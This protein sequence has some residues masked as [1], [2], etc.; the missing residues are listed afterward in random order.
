MYLFS[1]QLKIRKFPADLVFLGCTFAVGQLWEYWFSIFQ[2]VSYYYLLQQQEGDFSFNI[3]HFQYYIFYIPFY[4]IK[5]IEK[6]KVKRIRSRILLLHPAK[7][8]QM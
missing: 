5:R 2:Y 7:I 8:I 6:P 4:N 1:K 3:L